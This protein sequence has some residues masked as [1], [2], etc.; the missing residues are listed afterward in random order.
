[1]LEALIR[2]DAQPTPEQQQELEQAGYTIRSIAGI[3]LSGTLDAAQVDAVARLPFVRKIELARPLYQE[4]PQ[5]E[6]EERSE[7][8]GPASAPCDPPTD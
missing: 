1:M 2:T 4:Q 6:V 3:V 5:H 8:A 7:E